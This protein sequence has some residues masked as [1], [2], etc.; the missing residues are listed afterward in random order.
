MDADRCEAEELQLGRDLKRWAKS[1][2]GNKFGTALL[3]LTSWNI[4]TNA[5]TAPQIQGRTT[6]RGANIRN[7]GPFRPPLP[8]G[9]KAS[10]NAPFVPL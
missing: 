4:R 10:M 9:T 6:I 2:A 3:P 5:R 1:H 7:L 8:A